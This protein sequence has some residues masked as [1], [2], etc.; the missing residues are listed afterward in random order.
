MVADLKQCIL[1]PQQTGK[2]S[3]TSGNYNVTVVQ[4]EMVRSIFGQMR[5]PVEKQIEI[6]SNNGT[7]N[8]S[9]L[10]EPRPA[11]FIGAVGSFKAT[12]K[13]LNNNLKTNDS[14]TLRLTISGTGNLKI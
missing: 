13:M 2:L 9:A 10:P 3:I 4:Y 1:F 11:D 7:I 14:G 12:A 8:I 6:K 5:R